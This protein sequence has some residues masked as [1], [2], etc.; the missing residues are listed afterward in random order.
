MTAGVE[1]SVCFSSK[2]FV[3]VFNEANEV[4]C[5]LRAL[6]TPIAHRHEACCYQAA[7][8]FYV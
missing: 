1:Y 4:L 3:L 7:A 8:F 6:I 2:L 5:C